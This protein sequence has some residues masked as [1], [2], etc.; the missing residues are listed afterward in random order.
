VSAKLVI[1]AVLALAILYVLRVQKRLTILAAQ[2]RGLREQALQHVTYKPVGD[3]D[4]AD[5]LADATR[6]AEREGFRILG[7]HAEEAKLS[8]SSRPMRWFVDREGTTFGW[9]SPFETPGQRHVVIVLM[10]HELDRVTITAR[11]PAAST[12]SRPPFV[13]LQHIPPATS[14]IAVVAKHRAK[15]RFDDPERAFIPVKTFDEVVHELDRMRD[16]SIAWREA[17]PMDALLDADL[18]SLLGGEYAKLGAAM[19]RRLGR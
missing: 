2:I 12:L 18:R 3:V 15:A 1:V 19:K 11:Q 16:K 14:F 4:F 7:D 13:T 10:S 5:A 6:E 17:Q 9:M 8:G